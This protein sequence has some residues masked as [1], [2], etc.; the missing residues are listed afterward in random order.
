MG[1]SSG[2]VMIIRAEGLAFIGFSE[3]RLVVN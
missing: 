2:G 1:P 3:L